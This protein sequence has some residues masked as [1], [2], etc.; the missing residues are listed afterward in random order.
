MKT[1]NIKKH[2][3]YFQAICSDGTYY[4]YS[5]DNINN[6]KNCQL[7]SCTKFLELGSR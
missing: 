6:T 1:K 4:K 3:C 7:E 5:L 2:I